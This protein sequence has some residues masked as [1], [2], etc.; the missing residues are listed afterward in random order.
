MTQIISVRIDDELYTSIKDMDINI[1]EV[2][3]AA[4]HK[5]VRDMEKE[6][7]KHA[8]RDVARKLKENGINLGSEENS[9][10]Q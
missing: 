7:M 9:R 3:K 10:G 2:V 6:R 4:L 8:V 5:K 1:T